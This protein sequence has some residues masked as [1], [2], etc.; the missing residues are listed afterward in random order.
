MEVTGSFK[1]DCKLGAGHENSFLFLDFSFRLLCIPK[2]HF[3][4]T[5]RHLFSLFP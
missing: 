1:R 4:W 3:P 5:Y 2:M